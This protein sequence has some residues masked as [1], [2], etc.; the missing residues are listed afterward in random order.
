MK[1]KYIISDI[2][3]SFGKV[4]SYI[5]TYRIYRRLSGFKRLFYTGWVMR[6]FK[7]CG[8]NVNLFPFDT[9]K[10]PQYI[11][12]GDKTAIGKRAVLTAWDRL[13]DEKFTP[14]IIIGKNVNIGDDCHI[15][16]VNKIQ[17]G[18]NV[19][20]GK[21]ILITDN[22]HGE[23]VRNLLDIPPD[24]RP[25]STKGPVIIEENVWI[26]E[27]ASIMPAVHIGK[28][29]IVAANSVVTKDVPPYSIVGG[30]P[31]K[32]IKTITDI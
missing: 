7:Y 18:D 29:S 25:L 14:E 11:S 1:L 30:S 12:I 28:G 26:G 24:D 19:L 27:K 5:Y 32:I 22:S 2:A 4:C 21:K 13:K 17:I 10:G 9:L 20:M 16:S 23:F 8:K 3:R 15:T 31:A 6:E